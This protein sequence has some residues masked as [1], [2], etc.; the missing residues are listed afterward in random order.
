MQEKSTE[1][2][3]SGTQFHCKCLIHTNKS[4]QNKRESNKL[5]TTEN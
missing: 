2:G 1:V 3:D 5:V 4:L